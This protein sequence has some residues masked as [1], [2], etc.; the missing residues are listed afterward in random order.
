[1]CNII[2][3]I[4]ITFCY[5]SGNFVKRIDLGTIWYLNPKNFEERETSESLTNKEVMVTRVILAAT[6][7]EESLMTYKVVWRYRDERQL[8]CDS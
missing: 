4:S 1:M 3:I 6:I 8:V 2:F 7:P 5:F